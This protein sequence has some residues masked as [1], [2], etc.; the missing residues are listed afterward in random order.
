[1]LILSHI[2]TSSDDSRE[3]AW[4]LATIAHVLF[5]ALVLTSVVSGETPR[6]SI[7]GSF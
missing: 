2:L 5:W 6:F 7:G 3:M 1:M 4:L